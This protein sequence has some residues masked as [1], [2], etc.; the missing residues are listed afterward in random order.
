MINDNLWLRGSLMWVIV[1]LWLSDLVAVHVGAT[2]FLGAD[3]VD[4]TSP[5]VSDRLHRIKIDATSRVCR[6]VAPRQSSQQVQGTKA[7]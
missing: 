6:Q 7:K 3:S 2:F 1:N 4:S 5:L